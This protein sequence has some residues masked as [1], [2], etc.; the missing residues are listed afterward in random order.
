MFTI[1]ELNKLTTDSSFVAD[2][3]ELEDIDEE[4]ESEAGSDKDINTFEESL[5]RQ[6]SSC[7]FSSKKVSSLIFFKV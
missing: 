6:N 3:A 5:G 1:L 4:E 7:S 2:L